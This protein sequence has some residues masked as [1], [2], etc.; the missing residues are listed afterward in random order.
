MGRM[1]SE[2]GRNILSD[3]KA[4]GEGRVMRETGEQGKGVVAEKHGEMS[5]IDEREREQ[6]KCNERESSIEGRGEE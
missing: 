5:R 3:G 6:E 2:T 1:I 4:E